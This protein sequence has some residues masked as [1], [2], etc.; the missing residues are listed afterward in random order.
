MNEHTDVNLQSPS[1]VSNI[2][3]EFLTKP[4]VIELLRLG[5]NGRNASEQLRNLIRRNGLPVI[6]RGGLLLFR[7]SAIDAWLDEGQRGH[8]ARRRH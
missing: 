8:S 1:S 4:E 6:R 2:Q 3:S 5:C 7:R